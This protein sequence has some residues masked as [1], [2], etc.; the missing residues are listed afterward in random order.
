MWDKGD[1][2]EREQ[3]AYSR[4]R[5]NYT[6]DGQRPQGYNT[7]DKL[8]ETQDCLYVNKTEKMIVLA[9]VEAYRLLPQNRVDKDVEALCR[10]LEY[11]A[12]LRDTP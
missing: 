5:R 4:W 1:T 7:G 11:W 3:M 8:E 10:K 6:P 2:K 9:A 12:G